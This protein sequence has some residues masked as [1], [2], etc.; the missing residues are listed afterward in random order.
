MERVKSIDSKAVERFD[1]AFV[2]S[3]SDH[4]PRAFKPKRARNGTLAHAWGK[5][6][7]AK[8]DTD[9]DRKQG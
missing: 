1:R 8:M 2:W 6:A 9:N 3:K 5:Q 4:F 7:N